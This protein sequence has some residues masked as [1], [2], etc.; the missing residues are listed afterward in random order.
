EAILVKGPLDP[1]ASYNLAVDGTILEASNQLFARA[2]NLLSTHLPIFDPGLFGRQGKIMDSWET[3]RH[4][5]KPCDELI[6][7]LKN[8]SHIH[9]VSV[10]TKYHL[11][12]QAQ[13]VRIEG[14]NTQ[15]KTWQDIIA[16]TDLQGHA[17][18]NMKASTDDAVFSQIKV[19]LY[20]DGGISRL[21]L[22]DET[23]PAAEKAK[24]LSID[25]AQSV[26]FTDVIPQTIRS[27]AP[28]YDASE[29]NIKNNW[30][31]LEPGAEVDVASS[32]FGGRIVKATNEHYGPAAQV[33]SP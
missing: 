22:Y 33:I 17:L 14:L 4:N 8:P 23:L 12:N 18:K 7:E 10:S 21:G 24:F 20:P 5:Q 27:L 32:A 30:A 3:V 9:Y 11:G 13:F 28:K 1:L 2:E 19:S 29:E 6:F 15:T 16:K 26:V 25:Q 31:R